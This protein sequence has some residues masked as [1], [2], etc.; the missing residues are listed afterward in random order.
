MGYALPRKALLQSGQGRSPHFLPR[1]CLLR[2]SEAGEGRLLR[3]ISAVEG[4]SPAEPGRRERRR[5][6]SGM[7]AQLPRPRPVASVSDYASTETP[8]RPPG[9]AA[10]FHFPSPFPA[11]GAGLC[12]PPIPTGVG[13]AALPAVGRGRRWGYDGAAFPRV[14]PSSP[15]LRPA[16]GWGRA[17]PRR[18]EVDRSTHREGRD[19]VQARGGGGCGAGRGN[20]HAAARAL[21]PGARGW[22]ALGKEGAGGRKCPPPA[23]RAGERRDGGEAEVY[24]VGGGALG[25]RWAGAPAPS[26]RGKIGA[27]HALRA[28]PLRG[29]AGADVSTHPS[30]A[31]PRGA[32]VSARPPAAEAGTAPSGRARGG[33]CSGVGTRA[34]PPQEVSAQPAWVS[35]SLGGRLPFMPDPKQNGS[36][37]TPRTLGSAFPPVWKSIP[38]RTLRG[39]PGGLGPR[40]S[41]LPSRQAQT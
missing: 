8:T 39:L 7:A 23:L 30:A 5:P 38:V 19:Q 41:P 22:R 9:P 26:L 32:G 33:A 27:P 17:F 40:P 35:L 36:F 21:G 20:P 16:R 1:S 3:P 31:R 10:R 25:A 12:P 34:R 13:T 4:A 29:R 11:G 24:P 2:S 6:G 37:K 18:R 28:S 14:G 15:R